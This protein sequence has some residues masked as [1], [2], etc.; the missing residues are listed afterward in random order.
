MV[1]YQDLNTCSWGLK[2]V[3][4]LEQYVAV[5]IWPTGMLWVC[6]WTMLNSRKFVSNPRQFS[7]STGHTTED[8]HALEQCGFSEV[9]R[10][11]DGPSVMIPERA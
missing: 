2:V 4:H 5:A 11:N 9:P 6:T 8:M 7:I 1:T 10:D 3:L